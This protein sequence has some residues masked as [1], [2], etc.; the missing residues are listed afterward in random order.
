VGDFFNLAGL[1]VIVSGHQPVGDAP[2]PIQ[3]RDI[4]GRSQNKFVICADTSYSGDTKWMNNTK[5]NRR[6][7]GRGSA[8]SGRGDVAVSEILLEQDCTSLAI[9]AIRIR[10]RLSDGSQ[11]ESVTHLGDIDSYIG[12]PV[13][14]DIFSFEG[15]IQD[16]TSDK[17]QWYVK[18]KLEEGNYLLSTGKGYEVYN[19]V[20]S[21]KSDY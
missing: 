14:R 17:V 18:S 21:L 11:H 10:G 16:D 6:N 3:I 19:S 1:D 20:A 7:L 5:D 4:H 12:R 2:F 9:L 13:D 15:S 8:V